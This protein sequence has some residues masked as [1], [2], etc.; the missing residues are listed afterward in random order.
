[1]IRQLPPLSAKSRDS[2]SAVVRAALSLAVSVSEVRS[3]LYAHLLLE[4]E[5]ILSMQPVVEDVVIA[6]GS[7][8]V[9]H[10]RA[11]NSTATV[12]QRVQPTSDEDPQYSIH[13]PAHEL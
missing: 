1:M 4:L 13:P 9:L 6:P 5:A 12:L 7:R 8:H 11:D 3:C 2:V 10:C